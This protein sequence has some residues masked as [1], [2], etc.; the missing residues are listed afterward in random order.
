MSIAPL[1]FLMILAQSWGNSLPNCLVGA[2]VGKNT[3][4]GENGPPEYRREP[5]GGSFAFDS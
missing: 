4:I 5:A 2:E 3:A 1:T